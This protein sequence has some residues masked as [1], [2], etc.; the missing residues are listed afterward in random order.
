MDPGELNS[1]PGVVDEG[2]AQDFVIEDFC[3][4]RIMEIL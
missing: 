4:P 2:R 3:F 1:S